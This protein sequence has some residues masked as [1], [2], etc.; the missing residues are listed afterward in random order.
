MES[1]SRQFLGSCPVC[2]EPFRQEKASV[3]ESTDNA[4]MVHVDCVGCAGSHLL[5]VESKA[6]GLI[7]TIGMPTDLT[8]GDVGRFVKRQAAITPDDVLELHAYLEERGL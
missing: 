6:P 3:V 8:K 5:M 2:G 7:T 4:I 1:R